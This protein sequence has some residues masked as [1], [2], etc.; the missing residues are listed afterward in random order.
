MKKHSLTE[1]I[2][3][4]NDIIKSYLEARIDLWKVLFLEK[5]TKLGTYF[6]SAISIVVAILFMF[7]FL[8]FAFSFWYGDTY[9]KISDGFLI[10]AGF[11][12][13]MAIL[14][15]LL[16]KPLFSNSIIKKV[17]S[18]IFTDEGDK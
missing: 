2:S 16:R 10:S 6:I 11:F 12:V 5:T 13:L 4:L 14:L 9:G 18:L 8:A 15:F 1:N 3:E 7:V 17:A